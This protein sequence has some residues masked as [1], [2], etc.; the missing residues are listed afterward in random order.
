[1]PACAPRLRVGKAFRKIEMV[2]PGNAV[3]TVRIV[4]PVGKSSGDLG[5]FQRR[6]GQTAYVAKIVGCTADKGRNEGALW[7]APLRIA[8]QI[9][10]TARVEIIRHFPQ[11][12]WSAHE[13]ELLE[14]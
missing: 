5:Q 14:S 4:T 13:R 7:N 8:L 6:A 2:L 9:L 1:M 12:P 3:G 11:R 10:R